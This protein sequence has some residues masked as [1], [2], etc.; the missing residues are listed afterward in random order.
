MPEIRRNEPA[1]P[2]TGGIS[3]KNQEDIAYDCVFDGS[4]ASSL[5]GDQVGR[6]RGQQD[7]GSGHDQ[8]QPVIPPQAEGFDLNPRLGFPSRGTFLK[9]T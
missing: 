9:N 1:S 3:R 8:R 4:R 5:F 7:G 6:H 2:K